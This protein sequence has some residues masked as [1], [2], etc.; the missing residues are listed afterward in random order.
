MTGDVNLDGGVSLLDRATLQQNL[1]TDDRAVW[2][3]GDLNGDGRVNRTD[4]A[5]LAGAYG[6]GIVPV[7]IDAP[8]VAGSPPGYN[9]QAIPEP[10]SVALVVCAV[11]G[12]LAFGR[13]WHSS[14]RA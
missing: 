6:S 4:V 7:V 12:L 10:S 5:L 3:D 2:T 14:I 9:P 1:G 11:G 13:R 8:G